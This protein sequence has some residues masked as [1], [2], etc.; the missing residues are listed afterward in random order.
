MV[1]PTP[2]TTMLASSTTPSSFWRAEIRADRCRERPTISHE[3]RRHP[4]HHGIVRHVAG[5]HGACSHHRVITDAHSVRDHGMG[6][7]PHVLAHADAERAHGLLANTQIG[8][9]TM[10]E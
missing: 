1:Y 3:P 4:A 7:D 5:D 10:V 8:R 9:E 6:A 2:T